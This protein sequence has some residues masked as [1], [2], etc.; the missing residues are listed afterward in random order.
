M[1]PNTQA[2]VYVPAKEAADIKEG[3]TLLSS[4]KG[5]K[6]TGRQQGYVIVEVGSGKYHFTAK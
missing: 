5:A 4:V 2:I 6:I 3:G 1:P